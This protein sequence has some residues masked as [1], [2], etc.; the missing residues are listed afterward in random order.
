MA[1][2]ARCSQ[3]RLGL[4]SLMPKGLSKITVDK[5]KQKVKN[6]NTNR[7]YSKNHSQKW[8]IH[9]KA[10]RNTGETL[11]THIGDNTSQRIFPKARAYIL[12]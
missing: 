9:K 10:V 5:P 2:G 1:D 6:Q 12:N 3:Q 8:V 7:R 4:R 11:G